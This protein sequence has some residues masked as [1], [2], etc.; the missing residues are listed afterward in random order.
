[1]AQKVSFLFEPLKLS[2]KRRVVAQP[3]KGFDEALEGC[4]RVVV[5]AHAKGQFAR[6]A[7]LDEYECLGNIEL[8]L[9][10][11]ELATRQR[12]GHAQVEVVG[13]H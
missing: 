6:Y 3:T 12:T 4:I 11:D 9:L 5:T 13:V 1:M 10:L 2:D 7:F 8:E